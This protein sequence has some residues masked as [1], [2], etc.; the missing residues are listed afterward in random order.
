MT[1]LH[2]SSSNLHSSATFGKRHGPSALGLRLPQDLRRL[3]SLR[4]TYGR[5]LSSTRAS[6]SCS[7][8]RQAF[9]REWDDTSSR[10]T[11]G[12]KNT[13]TPFGGVAPLRTCLTFPD[14]FDCTS[15]KLKGGTA[16]EVALCQVAIAGQHLVDCW[17]QHWP[18]VWM[19]PANGLE[20]RSMILWRMSACMLGRIMFLSTRWKHL[21]LLQPPLSSRKKD[22]A[23][24]PRSLGNRM[25]HSKQPR[26]HMRSS[27]QCILSSGAGFVRTL[28]QMPFSRSLPLNAGR[29][30]STHRIPTAV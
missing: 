19:P 13:W 28:Q 11:R 20:S 23:L 7:S 2:T 12:M 14:M 25:L 6:R 24:S 22:L 26:R 30:R 15:R 27:W 1:L 5:S 3:S 17:E 29:S 18:H 21:L 8:V 16:G 9:W 4:R 10:P